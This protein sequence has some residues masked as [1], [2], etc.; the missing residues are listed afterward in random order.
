[1]N[2]RVKYLF[3]IASFILITSN[4][5]CQFFKRLF[6]SETDT[7]YIV[8]YS[9]ELTTRIFGSQKY[10][11]FRLYDGQLEKG[12]AYLP[13]DRF[14][15]GIGANHGILGINLGI[16]FPFIN[17]DDDK[18][19]TTE[20]TNW[21]T[22][23]IARKVFIDGILQYYK[24]YYLSNSHEMIQSWPDDGTYMIRGD[25]RTFSIGLSILYIFN[26][27]KFSYRAGF[28]QN[29]WQKKSAGSFLAGG[30]AYYDIMKGD[31]TLIPADLLHP[32]FYD[33]LHFS[34]AN[35]FSI[36]PMVGY[37]HTF[38]LKQH[39]FLSLSLT[40]N[41]ALGNSVLHP[42]NTYSESTKSGLTF[43]LNTVPR[44][45]LGYNSPK[46]CFDISYNNT[47]SRNQAPF[48]QG[49]IQFD[50][51]NFRFNIVHRFHIKKPLKILNPGLGKSS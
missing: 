25:I 24:G 9:K 28:L 11:R 6:S 2:G 27:K 41:L 18:Y 35:I 46:W 22:H 19:G 16:N 45:A 26:N 3:L 21:T 8:D 34:R 29:E 37:A 32:S 38:V 47:A 43:N 33:G 17:N 49:W 5:H 44:L 4:L 20:Y 15:I 31:S 12:L 13:N 40:V 42:D 30:E 39:W 23:L 51:G 48:D 50:T 14:L 1:M 36:G 10:A 7:S